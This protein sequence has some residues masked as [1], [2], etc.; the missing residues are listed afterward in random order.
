MQ[1]EVLDMAD[2]NP[3][4]LEKESRLIV[5][6]S[7]WT[8]GGAPDRVAHFF[9]WVQYEAYDFRVGND[10]LKKL[11]FAVFGLGGALYMENFAKCTAELH[12]SLQNKLGATAL[13][14][15]SRGD[16]QTNLQDRF[17]VWSQRVLA[18]L[19]GGHDGDGV[20]DDDDETSSVMSSST[21]A[22]SMSMASTVNGV[23]RPPRKEYQRQQRAAKKAAE[24]EANGGSLLE[25]ED[26]INATFV[27]YEGDSDEEDAA[28]KAAAAKAALAVGT[29]EEMV[30]ME[31]L[32]SVIKAGQE[33]AG[34]KGLEMVTT[35]Q[36]QALTKE[37][38]KIIG[39]HSA[40]KLCRW[41]KHQLRG[42]GGCYKHTFYGI[43]SY[44][45]MEA[46]PSLACASKV[47]D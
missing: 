30:D 26:R 5:L 22:T 21:V 2:Y 36:R 7:T 42:R 27:N 15:Y 39:T 8:D 40:V 20:D 24:A 33:G 44:Q 45:C 29:D 28:D 46:T 6:C 47:A 9:D 1:V 31:D 32:G 12:E 13:V 16:D 35:L 38:Y 3:E 10:A 17:R 11:S 18:A 4:R 25:E 37:G 19:T 43:T 23:K 14:P 34:K 41:T